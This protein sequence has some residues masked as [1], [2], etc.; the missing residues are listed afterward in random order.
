MNEQFQNDVTHILAAIGVN[1]AIAGLNYR[2]TQEQA[3]ASRDNVQ[4]HLS[5]Y[6]P[7]ADQI[8]IYIDRMGMVREPHLYGAVASAMMT[9]QFRATVEQIFANSAKPE[10][11]CLKPHLFFKT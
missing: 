6:V 9:S 4:K 11:N 1:I 7:T 3:D 8:I 10:I 2:L 5:V